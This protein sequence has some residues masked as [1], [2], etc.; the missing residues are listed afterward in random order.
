MKFFNSGI[1][2]EWITKERLAKLRDGLEPALRESFAGS[3]FLNDQCNV[4]IVVRESLDEPPLQ[5][6][7]EIVHIIAFDGE[8]RIVG[9]LFDIP[10]RN[11]SG[12]EATDTGWFF[13]VPWLVRDLRRPLADHIWEMA[14]GQMKRAGFKL[15]RTTIGTL[16][17][18]CYLEKVLGLSST[19]ELDEDGRKVWM[20][21]L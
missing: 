10:T 20:K 14:L 13:T 7:D 9:G 19:G 4:D 15:F 16:R 18:E 17:G 5:A 1:R 12:A 11:F 3:A 2:L 21:I 6:M 8:N